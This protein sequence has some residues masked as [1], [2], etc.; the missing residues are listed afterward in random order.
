M[1]YQLQRKVSSVS[2]KNDSV[3]CYF[4]KLKRLWDELDS[5]HV[6]PSCTCGVL[7]EIAEIT[8]RNRL[9]QFLMGLNDVFE[10]TRNQI[11]LTDPL[12]SVN[13]AY[14]TITKF[15]TQKQELTN[16]S[17]T[18]GQNFKRDS[19]KYDPKKGHCDF[20]NMDGHIREGCFKIIGYPDWFKY[21]NKG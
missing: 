19:K 20:C 21:K 12:P 7:K 18:Q 1:I 5:I 9:M 2:Q 3:A 14:S 8:N 6:L 4:T 10:P 11:L 16:F 15:E 13:K 17:D